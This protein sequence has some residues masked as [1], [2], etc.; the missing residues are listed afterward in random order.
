MHEEQARAEVANTPKPGVL[1]IGNFLSATK[2]VRSL[3]EELA[4]GLNAAGWSVITASSHT[5][6]VGRLFDFLRTVLRQRSRYK[7]AQV[8]VY[9]GLAFVWAELVCSALRMICKPYVLTLRGGNLPTFASGSDY[10]V[11]RLLR[12]AS[13]VTAPSMFL[14]ERMHRYREDIIV[15]PNQLNLTN[16]AFSVR[17]HPAPKLI[18]LRALHDI[19]NPSLAIRVVS[20]LMQN[21]PGVLLSMIGPD[22]GDGSLESAR[23]L[24]L[25]LG[26]ADKVSFV[27]SV[28]KNSVAHWLN[29]GDI[30]LNTT[31][32]DNMPVTVLEAMACGLCV[33]STNVG[34]I[35]YLLED[36]R[37]AL[38]V[39][40]DDH[41]AMTTAVQRL[42][43]ED[44]LAKRLS[45]NARRKA[46][47]FS[48]SNILP[49]WEKL[50]MEVAAQARS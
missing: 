11:K 17:E 27:G 41:L 36:E 13:A 3:C 28:P 30:F 39:P 20:L 23:Q 50:L 42:V 45:E 37:D 35:P 29:Q 26:I 5:G 38:L 31:R 48:W 33:V 32:V 6:R 8:D 21:F 16:Y 24:A 43:T 34:G 1:L 46:E 4:L 7:V 15:L 40:D 14:R 12:S 44:G 19:Y 18:W 10:R 9:S 49:K 2:G 47:Q 25:K 22:K